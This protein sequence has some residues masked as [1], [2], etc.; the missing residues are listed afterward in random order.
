MNTN[1]ITTLYDLTFSTK[2]CFSQQT[3]ETLSS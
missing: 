2:S 1:M 3:L